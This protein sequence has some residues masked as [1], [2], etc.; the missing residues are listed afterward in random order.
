M[1]FLDQSDDGT[2]LSWLSTDEKDRLVERSMESIF[3]CVFEPSIAL[4]SSQAAIAFGSLV[5]QATL[6]LDERKCN[7]V[8]DQL[9]RRINEVFVTGKSS[10]RPV[11]ITDCS[12]FY[13][14][15]KLAKKQESQRRFDRTL[16]KANDVL[17]YLGQVEQAKTQSDCKPVQ[18]IHS[19][20]YGFVTKAELDKREIIER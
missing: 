10:D 16:A 15:E 8:I 17:L 13:T 4:F 14:E 20:K 5:H 19:E 2:Y 18:I 6:E 12:D 3:Q 7:K 9:Y 1:I 11:R